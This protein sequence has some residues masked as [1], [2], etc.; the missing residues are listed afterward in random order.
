MKRDCLDIG[1]I[2]AFLDSELPK[3]ELGRVASHLGDCD[4]CA[5]MLA[6]AEDESAIVFPAL[7]CEFDTLVP[8]QRLWTKINGEIETER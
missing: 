2:Q 8:T 3:G 1:T 5:L 6:T 7:E 4:D